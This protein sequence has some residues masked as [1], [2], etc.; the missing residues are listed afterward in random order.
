M[1]DHHAVL[2]EHSDVQVGHQDQDARALVP[3][4]DTDVVQLGSIAKCEA[5]SLVDAVPTDL[6]MGQE[7]CPPILM[8][9]LSRARQARMGAHPR[10][11]CERSSL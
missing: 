9:A 4:S 5:A 7:G 3:S 1:A 11:V 10:A 2:V 8:V 6:G